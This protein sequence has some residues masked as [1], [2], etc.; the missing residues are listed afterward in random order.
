MSHE[1]IVATASITLE[2][3]DNFNAKL[4]FKRIYT[5]LEAKRLTS[6]NPIRVTPK[7]L[8]LNIVNL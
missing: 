4:A 3:D 2:Q 7:P 1:N 8:H 6:E 5:L